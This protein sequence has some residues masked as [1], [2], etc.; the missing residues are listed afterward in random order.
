M[1]I[2]LAEN[3]KAEVNELSELCTHITGIERK[4]KYQQ[5]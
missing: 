2:I 5:K 4:L 1:P 3:R